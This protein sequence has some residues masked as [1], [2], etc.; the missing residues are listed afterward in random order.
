MKRDVLVGGAA[1]EIE[2]DA[3]RV[4]YEREGAEPVAGEFEVRALDAGTYWVR[5]GERSFRVMP[6]SDGRVSVNGVSLEMEVFD[7]RDLRAAGRGA[8]K[9]GRQEIVS[10]MPGKVVRVLVAAGDVVEEGQGVV[11]VEA[12]KMQNEMKAP[13]SGKVT[14]VRARAE[15]TVAANE[16]LVVIE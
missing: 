13:K 9:D 10:P 7:P 6:G 4:R 3:G 15:A 8:S 2:V 5:I 1:A 11:V 16:V 12:M 14:D